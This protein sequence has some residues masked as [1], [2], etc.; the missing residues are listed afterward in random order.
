MINLKATSTWFKILSRIL[1]IRSTRNTS[2]ESLLKSIRRL[3]ASTLKLR[4]LTV[5]I[6]GMTLSWRRYPLR[7]T[8]LRLPIRESFWRCTKKSTGSIQ[9]CKNWIRL[10]RTST[11]NLKNL[12]SPRTSKLSQAKL[13]WRFKSKKALTQSRMSYKIW[14]KLFHKTSKAS[15]IKKPRI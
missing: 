14:S 7:W 6:S 9:L 15:I 8:K 2:L 3:K 5:K 13:V 10:N 12:I 1:S 11:G 4:I